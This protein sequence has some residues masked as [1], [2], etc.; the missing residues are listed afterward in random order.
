MFFSLFIWGDD[1]TTLILICEQ[2]VKSSPSIRD[3]GGLTV[4][5]TGRWVGVDSAW[6]QEKLKARKMLEN[7]GESHLSNAR[8]VGQRVGFRTRW[9]VTA[10]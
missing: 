1:R 6:E 5:V 9:P 2:F 3:E 8:F 7:G 10:R 4:C